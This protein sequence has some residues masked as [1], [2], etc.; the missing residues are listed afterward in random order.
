MILIFSE[1]NDLSTDEVVDWLLNNNKTFL[2]LNSTSGLKIDRAF[3]S[4]NKWEIVLEHG[5]FRIDLSKLTS[6]WYRRGRFHFEQ[7]A[8]ETRDETINV[9][10]NSHT[11]TELYKLEELIHSRLKELKHLGSFEENYINKL[12]VLQLAN[13]CGLKVPSTIIT[14]NKREVFEFSKKNKGRIIT[15]AIKDRI[16]LK[17]K[18]SNYYA[19]TILVERKTIGEFPETF[20]PTLFQTCIEKRYELRIFYLD[21]ECYSSVI[22]SQSD[23]KTIIDFR[24]YNMLKPNRVCPYMLPLKISR[25]I[26]KL[27]TRL[28]LR[29]GSIDMLVNQDGEYVFLEINPIGQFK[30]VSTP[31]NYYLEKRIAESLS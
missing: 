25:K 1:E 29:T 24:N 27:M 5:T 15:K 9:G 13:K 7:K 14:T 30:Q 4:E 23:P 31:C 8:V 20:I 3:L 12:N 11:A 21:G 28:N 6:F 19:N 2:R 16:H 22:F 18:G 17:F 26:S 10:L